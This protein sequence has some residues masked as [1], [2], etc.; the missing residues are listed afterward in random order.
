VVAVEPLAGLAAASYG[1]VTC[2]DVSGWRS[3]GSLERREVVRAPPS[4]EGRAQG[5]PEAAPP[6]EEGL[7][8]QC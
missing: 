8:L 7:A 4:D 3:P 6:S 2:D 5:E 1:L